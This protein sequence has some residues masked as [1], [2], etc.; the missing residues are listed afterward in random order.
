MDAKELVE[1]LKSKNERAVSTLYDQYAPPLYGIIS[2]MI[3]SDQQAE[4]VLEGTFLAILE[5]IHTYRDQT[6]LFTWM[7]QIARTV[8]RQ[9]ATA[10]G[11]VAIPDPEKHPHIIEGMDP[12]SREVMMRLC[13]RG[14]TVSETAQA[15]GIP[16]SEVRTLL[17][18][19]FRHI[20]NIKPS[21]HVLSVSVSIASILICCQ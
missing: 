5:E 15:L 3:P 19:A 8:A 9:N 10:S 2:R 20:N 21:A 4:A 18:S 17:K 12:S 1:L 11:A 14:S 6:H 7:V 16:V 13:C